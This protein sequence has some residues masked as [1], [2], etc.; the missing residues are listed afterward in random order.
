[1]PF[2]HSF[3]ILPRGLDPKAEAILEERIRTWG[4]VSFRPERMA[5]AYMVSNLLLD[6]CK[7]GKNKALY[8]NSR[9]MLESFQRL[10]PLHIMRDGYLPSW[11][12]PLTS[13]AV[14]PNSELPE[15]IA[16][17]TYMPPYAAWRRLRELCVTAME[18]GNHLLYKGRMQGDEE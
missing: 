15:M 18:Q 10:L 3:W 12:L 6:Y 8:I 5:E 9:M 16:I 1:M 17:L 13:F 7:R 11:G 14:I 4:T 2:K